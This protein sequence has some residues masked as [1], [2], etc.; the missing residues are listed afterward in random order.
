VG[1]CAQAQQCTVESCGGG[2]YACLAVADAGFQWVARASAKG[3]TC[4]DGNACTLGDVCLPDGGC[5]G[6]P[7]VCASPPGQCYSGAGSCAAGV[8]S[9]PPKSAGTACNAGDPCVVNDACNGAGVCAGTA[10]TCDSPPNTACYAAAGTCSGGQ[11]QY[12]ALP[13]GSACNG[14]CGNACNGAGACVFTCVGNGGSCACGNDCCSDTCFDG[15]CCEGATGTACGSALDC[16]CPL[17]TCASCGA[18]AVCLCSGS[19]LA[20]GTACLCDD[21]CTGGTCYEGECCATGGGGSLS[22]W[23]LAG[24]VLLFRRRGRRR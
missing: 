21:E 10:V 16:C 12:T 1:A 4:D 15:V 11:C 8:C 2:A 17:A 7:L 9:Y 24:A 23:G 22:I 19:L 20:N 18:G 14:G 5:A 3:G 6:S 13:A